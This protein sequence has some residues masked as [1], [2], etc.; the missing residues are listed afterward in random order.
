[1]KFSLFLRLVKFQLR[2]AEKKTRGQFVIGSLN[3]KANFH[4][5]PKG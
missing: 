4:L 3:L 2:K 1:M 5:L